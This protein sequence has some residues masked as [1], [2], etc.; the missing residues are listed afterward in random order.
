M[1][2]DPTSQSESAGVLRRP[3]FPAHPRPTGDSLLCR[4][5]P[6]LISVT[7]TLLHQEVY[8]CRPSMCD[9]YHSAT[10]NAREIYR[11]VR[12]FSSSYAILR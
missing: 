10:G 2:R 7:I 6:P 1:G 3:G 4:L 5:L 8:N 12:Y 11:I 9:R